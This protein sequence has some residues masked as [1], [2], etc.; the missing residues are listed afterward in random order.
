MERYHG[1]N[2]GICCYR[3]RPVCGGKPLKGNQHDTPTFGHTQ[4]LDTNLAGNFRKES[5][6][7]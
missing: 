5:A 2:M 3:E 4:E 1:G 6:K 7:A